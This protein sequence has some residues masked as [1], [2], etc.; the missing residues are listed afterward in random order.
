MKRTGSLWAISA[1]LAIVNFSSTARV[2]AAEKS[3][4]IKPGTHECTLTHDG[5]ER[6]YLLHVPPEYDRREAMPLVLFFHGGG[7]TAKHAEAH[8]GWN[9]KADKEGFIVV[10]PNGSGRIQTWNAMHGCGSALKNNVDDVGFVRELLKNLARSVKFDPAR[11]YATGMSNGAMLT[12]RLA[13]EMPRVFAAAAPVAGAIGGKENQSAK[14]KR[15]PEPG[16]PVPMMIIHGKEDTNVRYEGGQSGGIEKNRIDLSV[17]DAV[18]FWVKTNKCTGKPERVEKGNVITET[19]ASTAGN[20]VVLHSIL[21]GGHAWPG[22]TMLR[23]KEKDKSID[24]TDAIWEFFA[25]H[26]RR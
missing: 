23:R 10:Y 9:E 16:D 15:I 3:E 20:D 4:S 6:T 13:A 17:A 19:Y 18:A 5:V 7:G 24:A 21:N 1:A 8:Y 26:R 22:A 11:V 25:A 2:A 14:E 12:H